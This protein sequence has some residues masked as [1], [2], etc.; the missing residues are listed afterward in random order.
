M[1]AIKLKIANTKQ[2]EQALLTQLY[3]HLKNSASSPLGN[4]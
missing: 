2:E 4:L 3:A 1:E